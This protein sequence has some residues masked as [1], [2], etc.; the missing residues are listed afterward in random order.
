[1]AESMLGQRAKV[2]GGHVIHQV[3]AYMH[4]SVDL[5]SWTINNIGQIVHKEPL[6]SVFV[7]KTRNID[8]IDGI[9]LCCLF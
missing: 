5:W 2:R 3:K 4:V 7:L 6:A 1:M 9:F 8:I